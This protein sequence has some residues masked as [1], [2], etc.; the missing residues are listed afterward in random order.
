MVAN[1]ADGSLRAVQEAAWEAAKAQRWAW[2]SR[3]GYRGPSREQFEKLVIDAF[4]AAVENGVVISTAEQKAEF[5]RQY[6]THL[7]ETHI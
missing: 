3:E 1:H 2:R 4:R 6:E 5:V 7:F